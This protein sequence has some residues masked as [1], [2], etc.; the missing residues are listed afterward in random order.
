MSAVC[1][2][3]LKSM[4]SAGWKEQDGRASRVQV[5]GPGGLIL[6]SAQYDSPLGQC[7]PQASV[8][9]LSRECPHPVPQASGTCKPK[10]HDLT[11][12]VA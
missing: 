4:Q 7:K 12:V 2:W 6:S 1:A 10:R 5:G 9:V 3:L 11:E 8:Q